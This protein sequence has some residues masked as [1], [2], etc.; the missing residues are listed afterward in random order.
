MLRGLVLAGDRHVIELGYVASMRFF[1]LFF[2][3]M[4]SVR[5]PQTGVSTAETSGGTV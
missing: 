5:G 1:S 2:C 3:Y 4:A